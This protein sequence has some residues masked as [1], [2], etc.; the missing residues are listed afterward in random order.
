MDFRSETYDLLHEVAERLQTMGNYLS[1][2][3][4][5]PDGETD[6][7]QAD[8][9]LAQ[10]ATELGLVYAAFGRLSAHLSGSGQIDD[11]AALP[12]PSLVMRFHRSK[13][14]IDRTKPKISNDDSAI[15]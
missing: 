3:R 14:V 8:R 2:V 1:A 7:R 15:S 10:T 4:H 11:A 5:A 9:L 6:G 12:G 13:D